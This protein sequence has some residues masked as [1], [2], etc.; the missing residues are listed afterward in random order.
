M[1][2]LTLLRATF[3][4]NHTAAEGARKLWTL[5][6]PTPLLEQGLLEQVVQSTVH[7]PRMEIPVPASHRLCST[8]LPLLGEEISSQLS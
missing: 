8:E 2:Q 3:S 1:S 6:S 4:Q 7:P 5:P